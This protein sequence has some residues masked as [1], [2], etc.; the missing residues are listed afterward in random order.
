VIEP[1]NIFFMIGLSVIYLFLYILSI[2][3]IKNNDL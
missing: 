2:L 3:L 1:I